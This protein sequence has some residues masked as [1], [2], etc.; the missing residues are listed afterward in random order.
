MGARERWLF[1]RDGRLFVHE[2]NDG[3]VFLRR[4]PEVREWEVSVEEARE[5]YPDHYVRLKAEEGVTWREGRWVEW[6]DEL[7]PNIH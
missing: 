7:P 2:E 3:V 4:G 5:C 1:V 6:S